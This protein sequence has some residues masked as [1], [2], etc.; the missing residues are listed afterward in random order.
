VIL[1]QQ[2]CPCLYFC[3][4]AVPQIREFYD[5]DNNR[6]RL[7]NHRHGHSIVQIYNN[8]TMYRIQDNKKC[9]ASIVNNASRHGAHFVDRQ[10]GHLRRTDQMFSISDRDAFVY[11]G[12]KQVRGIWCDHWI[13]QENQTIHMHGSTIRMQFSIDWYFGV[14]SWLYRG[15]NGVHTLPVRAY[16]RGTDYNITGGQV[17]VEGNSFEHMYD[18]TQFLPGTPDPAL[19][20]VP[21]E[22]NCPSPLQKPLPSFPDNFHVELEVS[23]VSAQ[24]TMTVREWSDYDQNKFRIDEVTGD[25]SIKTIL[26]DLNTLKK[27]VVTADGSCAVTAVPENAPFYNSA[28]HHLRHT[29][30]RVDGNNP[31]TYGG[32]TTVRGIPCD[33]WFVSEVNSPNPK[34]I[35]NFTTVMYFA[36]QS[37]H[38]SGVQAGQ[39]A[40]IR[41]TVKGTELINGGALVHF[42]EVI[43]YTSIQYG[44]IDASILAV[45]SQ[46]PG[47]RPGGR[48]GRHHDSDDG[49]AGR[50]V[51]AALLGVVIGML[52]GAIGMWYSKRREQR[53]HSGLGT[54][55]HIQLQ[56]DS[57][58]T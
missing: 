11:Q 3:L 9:E 34:G 56:E 23:V 42:D 27:Y 43:E 39:P 30:N 35:A 50:E 46:C 2:I 18:Y 13:A 16:V 6:I 15:E 51:M 31:L 48:P 5:Y 26:F 4:V 37:W 22:I 25:G 41:R 33:T 36:T 12:E 14:D 45:P 8:G 32:I 28:T 53:G 21:R 29:R 54:V 55:A 47:G 58:A 52:V 19:F 17:P 49:N 44:H 57:T 1:T 10:T 20:Q 38:M 7:E 40:P 24:L